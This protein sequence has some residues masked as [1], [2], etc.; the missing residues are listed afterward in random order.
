MIDRL[1]QRIKTVKRETIVVIFLIGSFFAVQPILLFV[2]P[3]S[4]PADGGYLHVA[5]L[6]VLKVFAALM[7]YG[8]TLFVAFRSFYHYATKKTIDY[9][10]WLGGSEDSGGLI[11]KIKISAFRDDWHNMNKKEARSRVQIFVAH[12]VAIVGFFLWQMA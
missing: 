5:L 11:E 10:V 1:I 2:D 6:G 9:D 8:V 4:A 3:T 12:S 7:A